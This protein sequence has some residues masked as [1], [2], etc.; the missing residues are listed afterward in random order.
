MSERNLQ[1]LKTCP[2]CQAKVECGIANGQ[3]SCWCFNLPR[4]LPL[5]ENAACLCPEC[6]QK[7]IA[8]KPLDSKAQDRSAP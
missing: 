2:K 4:V 8:A 1:I 3:E 6:L 7:Q 5:V